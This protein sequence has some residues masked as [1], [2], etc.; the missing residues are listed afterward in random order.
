MKKILLA[1]FIFIFVISPNAFAHTH[2]GS[3]S[4]KDGQV[5]TEKLREI[6]LNFEGKIEQGSKF[7]L[8][9]TQGQSI[10]VENISI[11]EGEMTGNLA[12]P[13]ENGEYLVNWNIIGADGHPID[14][15]FSFTVNV[16]G[17]E[18]P[19][20]PTNET[21][22]PVQEEATNEH[23]HEHEQTDEQLASE[24]TEETEESQLPSYLI[25]AIIIVLIVLII[26]TFFGLRRKK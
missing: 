11:D 26:G 10:P 17:S 9:N 16:S 2:L 12:N 20:E 1:T 24:E 8:S 6:T 13:L 25:P 22:Q 5:V 14:G 21:E 7:E 4:P 15:E 18:T 23:E 19:A 3:S